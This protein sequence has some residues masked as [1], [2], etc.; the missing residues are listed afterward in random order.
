[1]NSVAKQHVSLPRLRED[2]QLLKGPI[3]FDGSPTWNIYDPVCNKYFRIGWSVFQLISRWSIG[4]ARELLDRV[5]NETTAQV[6][7][8][9]VENLISFLH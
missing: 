7:E 1:M 2:L 5:K 4:N 3:A 8:E 6:K 9:D